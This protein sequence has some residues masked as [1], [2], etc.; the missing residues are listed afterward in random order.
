M[1][2]VEERFWARVFM[3]APDECWGWDGPPGPGGYG[4][5]SMG[6]KLTYAHRA[7]YEIATGVSPYGCLVC[8]T[9]DNPGCVN[10]AHLFLG[11]SADNSADMVRKG[12]SRSG[13]AHWRA[14]LTDAQVN[15]IR[16]RAAAGETQRSLAA[17]HGVSFQHVSDLCSGRRRDRRKFIE[18]ERIA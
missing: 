2:T 8:H 15:D 11:T 3:R 14:R 4:K 17:A 13:E 12:R 9:C 16:A 7:A 10:P 18:T 1:K 5:F 6:G